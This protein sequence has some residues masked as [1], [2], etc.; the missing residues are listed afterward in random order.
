MSRTNQAQCGRVV[1]IDPLID[2]YRCLM[3]PAQK[4][5]IRLTITTSGSN[6]LRLAPS[7][8]DALWLVSIQLPDMNGLELLEMLESL[9]GEFRVVIVDSH[10]SETHERQA[11]RFG[12]IQYACKPIQPQWL[13]AWQGL[14]S[15][16][17]GSID[18]PGNVPSPPTSHP[19]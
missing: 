3:E 14:K 8:A 18:V 17:L 19:T 13:P 15:P 12:A 11:L 2:D 6:A 5:L 10:Y 9:N 16:L 7:F 4:Q 1:V